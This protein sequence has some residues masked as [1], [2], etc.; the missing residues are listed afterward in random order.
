MLSEPSLM[1]H[2]INVEVINT[3]Q[4]SGACEVCAASVTDALQ[5]D[6]VLDSA[7]GVG[8]VNPC[9]AFEQ[10]KLVISAEAREA[11]TVRMR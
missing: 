4:M 5:G 8:R 10:A 11:Q 2:L 7:K 3:N 1:G 9:C 6:G